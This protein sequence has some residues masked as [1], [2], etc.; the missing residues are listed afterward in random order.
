MF[1]GTNIY[2]DN[3]TD[4]EKTVTCGKL[5]GGEFCYGIIKELGLPEEIKKLSGKLVKVEIDGQVYEAV[6]K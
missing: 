1:A 2:K 4:E 6:I 5:E 3:I